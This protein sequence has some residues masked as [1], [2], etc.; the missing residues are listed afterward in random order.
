M[1]NKGWSCAVP[2]CASLDAASL[3][4]RE[5]FILLLAIAYLIAEGLA[6]MRGPPANDEQCRVCEERHERMSVTVLL[7]E[8][9][10]WRGCTCW[11]LPAHGKVREACLKAGLIGRQRMQNLFL[12]SQLR[13]LVGA[14]ADTGVKKSTSAERRIAA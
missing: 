14:E 8:R 12:L 1:G 13:L 9:V 6:W 7:A 3:Y 11:L 5:S 2:V 4:E 10:R